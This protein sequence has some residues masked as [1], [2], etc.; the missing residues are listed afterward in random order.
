MD[1]DLLERLRQA[2]VHVEMYRPLQVVQ[3]RSAQQPHAP[4]AAD[5]GRQDRLHGRRRDRRSVGGPRPGP[6]SLA[7][8]AFPGRRTGG[9]AD[10][11]RV[12]RQLDQDD[13]RG[14]ERRRL[15]PAARARR[16]GRCP[17]VHLLTR[18]RQ[19]EHAP[20]VPDGDRSRRY[21]HRPGGLVLRA[22][23]PGGRSAARGAQ[24]RRAGSH[25]PAG[26]A[27]RFGDGAHRLEGALGRRCSRQGSRST[28]TSR[29]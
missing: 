17:G 24:T 20:H 27:H 22:R 6:R 10:A 5:R 29:R 3:P 1:Q 28:S 19:R 2:G 13:R 4:Q 21:Q 18:R 23:R 25:P 14:V 16:G 26:L 11:G 12:Q 9:G 8:R 7:R 15:F